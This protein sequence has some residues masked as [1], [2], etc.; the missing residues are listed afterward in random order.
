M[1]TSLERTTFLIDKTGNATPQGVFAGEEFN[2][3]VGRS[4]EYGAEEPLR[5][6]IMWTTYN[7]FDEMSYSDNRQ[8]NEQ[9]FISLNVYSIG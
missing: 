5:E 9:K 2:H 4:I 6:L 1:A 7:I 8:Q 3:L